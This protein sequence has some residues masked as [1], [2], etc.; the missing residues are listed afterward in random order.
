MTPSLRGPT[1]PSALGRNLGTMNRRNALHPG[2]RAFDASQHQVDDVLGH[3]VLAGRNPD[4]LAGD[5]VAPVAR[6]NRLGAKQR[7]VRAA[8]RLGQVHG[9]GPVA[10]RQMRQIGVFL[11][12]A[13]AAQDGRIVAVGQARIHGKGHVR[14]RRGFRIGRVQQGWQA[15]AAV[16]G[17]RRQ[18]HEP[19]LGHL[20]VGLGEPGRRG[21][22]IVRMPGAAFLVADAVQRRDDLFAELRAFGDDLLDQIEWRIGEAGQI[23]QALQ[24]QHIAKDKHLVV[25]RGSKGH[26]G[27]LARRSGYRPSRFPVR[28]RPADPDAVWPDAPPSPCRRC[29]DRLWPVRCPAAGLP[30]P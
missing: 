2:R 27:L 21:D 24:T 12:F 8:L 16:F 4:L 23:G 26:V 17:L 20:L 3:V 1:P 7:Q 10:G 28:F 5:P 25:G 29:A 9:A 22:R 19:G 6:R 11:L 18:G 14:R 13:A 15:L 30:V